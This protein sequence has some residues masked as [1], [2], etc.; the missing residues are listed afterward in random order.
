MLIEV[1]KV[2]HNKYFL[3]FRIR[4]ARFNIIVAVKQSKRISSVPIILIRYDAFF[5]AHQKT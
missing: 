4:L 1:K 3:L 5:L 2:E